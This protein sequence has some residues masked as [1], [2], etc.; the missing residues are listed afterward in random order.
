MA[1]AWI[2]MILCTPAIWCSTFCGLLSQRIL[3]LLPFQTAWFLP[4]RR[5]TVLNLQQSSQLCSKTLKLFEALFCCSYH[6]PHCVGVLYAHAS[7]SCQIFNC[8]RIWNFFLRPWLI[9]LYYRLAFSHIWKKMVCWQD[10]ECKQ[11][12]G[13]SNGPVFTVLFKLSLHIF[14]SPQSPFQCECDSSV[15][16]L[17][18]WLCYVGDVPL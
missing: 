9:V 2:G 7:S 15:K 18:V 3:L 1:F 13:R 6:P 8:F 12:G 11:E 5:L 10:C 16:C 14:F 4:R 17:G